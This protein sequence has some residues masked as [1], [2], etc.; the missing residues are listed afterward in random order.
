MD[1]QA[2]HEVML[3]VEEAKLEEGGGYDVPLDFSVPPRITFNRPFVLLAYDHVTGL[4]LLMGRITDPA[5][6]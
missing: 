1:T 5:D 4:V 3:E 6:V 2:S